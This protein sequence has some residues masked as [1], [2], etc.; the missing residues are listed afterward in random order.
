MFRR[1]LIANRGE[2]VR[3]VLRTC[4]RLGVEA[5]VVYS[6]ADRDAGYLEEA[7]EAVC[8]GPPPSARSYLDRLAVVQAA[9]QTGCSAIHP[10]WGFL[11]EDPLFAELCTQCGL[12]F[13]GPTPHVMRLMG[14]K[15]S[16]RRAAAAAGLDPIPG[17]PGILASAA[18]ARAVADEVGYPVILKADAG[19]GGRG[20]RR[21]DAP[22]G[23]EEAFNLASAE[24]E[25][26][27]ASG[28]LYLERYLEGGRHIEF[29]VLVDTYG[30]AIHVGERECSIQRKHQKLI[31]E[32]PSPALPPEV[33]AEAGVRAAQAAARV[34]YVG[35][36]TLECLL[37]DSGALRFMEMN[38]RLQVEHPVSELRSG[39]DLVEQQ[40]RI[41]AN[42]RLALSQADVQLTGSAIELR[43]NAE[44]PE[45]DFRPDPGTISRL[46]WP[47]GVRVESHIR[48]G[49]RIPPYYDS[50]I[51]KLI[52]HAA[53][54]PAAIQA[55]LQALDDLVLEGVHTTAPL[56]RA[57]L[58]SE[59]FG[60]GA[61]DVRSL[62]GWEH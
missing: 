59:A 22:E 28:A 60:S 27:F 55:A 38:A 44:D 41:A 3:R 57:V 40:L 54:R 17:S 51:A 58:S 7:D 18:E 47:E 32:S 1:I 43:L 24:A 20:M 39:I 34:G 21:C 53:D 12:T 61:Y 14:R 33:L 29:Q 30:N 62:P 4:R 52:V 50:L 6:S 8:L 10:G 23:I 31:E 16:A 36:G 35:A 9:R 45:H 11:S 49:Y 2:V 5:V 13:V 15:V 42:E 46:R 25:A 48:E 56:L 37:D 19:G 26:A